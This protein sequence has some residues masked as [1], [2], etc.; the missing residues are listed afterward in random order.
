MVDLFL[1]INGIEINA[2]DL[3]GRT[4]LIVAAMLNNKELVET[5]I[6]KEADANRRDHEGKTPLDHAIVKSN[7]EI[8][9]FLCNHTKL[10]LN[11]GV[12]NHSPLY[13]AT[14]MTSDEVFDT[15][16]AACKKLE[17][18]QYA[19]L[20]ELALH[21]AIAS[22]KEDCFNQLLEVSGV[23]SL[24]EDDDGWT[25]SM[26]CATCYHMT[27]LRYGINCFRDYLYAGRPLETRRTRRPTAKA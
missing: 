13:M 25:P 17:P 16:N 3:A 11:V 20:C 23:T 26:Y 21:A 18:A 24:V 27:V 2:A 15:V 5:L 7:S 1:S 19:K 14:R 22:N 9:E 8:T 12:R 10:E 6:A 4:P